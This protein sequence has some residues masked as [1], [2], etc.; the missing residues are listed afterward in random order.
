[1]STR[2]RRHHK[3]SICD[4]HE[5]FVDVCAGADILE[6]LSSRRRQIHSVAVLAHA[7]AD[8]A[9]PLLLSATLKVSIPS[10][11][12]CSWC[13][14][15]IAC[16]IVRFCPML[17]HLDMPHKLVSPLAARPCLPHS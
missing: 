10:P 4:G 14:A 8:V 6:Q 17:P 5:P 11:C 3:G 2:Y 7:S 13:K 9:T 16:Y 15:A 12:I 1:M